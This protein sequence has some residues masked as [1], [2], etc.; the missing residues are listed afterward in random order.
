MKQ[1]FETIDAIIFEAA[2]TL[3]AIET[4]YKQKEYVSWCRTKKLW[5]AQRSSIIVDLE[6]K[7]LASQVVKEVLVQKNSVLI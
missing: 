2:L 6:D 3:N 7:D 1:A 4:Q 5:V